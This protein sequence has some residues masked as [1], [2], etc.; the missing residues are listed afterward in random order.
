MSEGLRFDPH[1][2]AAAEVHETIDADASVARVSLRPAPGDTVLVTGASGFVGAAVARRLAPTGCRIRTLMR[3]SSP[4]A[5]IDGLGVQVHEGDMRDPGAV[6]SAMKG[7]RWLIH[8]AADYRLWAPDPAEIIDCNMRGTQVVME[9]ALSARVERIVYTSSVATLS[10]CHGGAPSSERDRLAKHD[11]IGAYKLSKVLAEDLIDRMISDRALPAI[12]VHPSTPIGPGDIKPTPTGRIIVE[13]ARGR[14]PVFVETGLNLVHVDDVADGHLRALERGR[15]GE[16]YILGGQNVAFSTMLA[17]IARLTG[18]RAPKL[19]L[20]HGAILPVAY[21]AEMAAR[22][23]GREPFVSLDSLRMSK[24]LMFYSSE[25]AE[26]ELGYRARPY[27]HA[28]AD[29]LEWFVARRYVQL[30]KSALPLSH[31][32]VSSPEPSF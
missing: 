15:I 22:V 6:A 23:T 1:A 28:L 8:A 5:N 10:P 14:I 24:H 32:H 19:K 29:A 20:P 7:V 18:R 31:E 11:A 16:R 21:A 13:A 2:D 30:K 12:I 17:D 26:K 27:R 25:K 9:A 3:P 4:R